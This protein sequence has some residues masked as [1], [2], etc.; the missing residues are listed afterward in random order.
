MKLHIP[1]V[2]GTAACGKPAMESR[3]TS[4]WSMSSIYTHSITS[5]IIS[6]TP[7]ISLTPTSSLTTTTN[8]LLLLIEHLN[9]NDIDYT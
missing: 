7:D 5:S 1:A 6:P 8:I 9:I 4:S 3:P 2:S